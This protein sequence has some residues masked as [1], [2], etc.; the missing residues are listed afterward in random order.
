MD[1]DGILLIDKPYGC[2]SFD[3]IRQLKF[4]FG[5][6]K[7]GHAGT[8]DPLATGLLIVVLGKA[9]KIS[10]QLMNGVKTYE[11]SFLLGM[12]TTTYDCEGDTVETRSVNGITAEDVQVAMQGFLGDQYQQPPMFSARKIHGVPLYKLAR[13]GQTVE[14]KPSF[15]TLFKFDCIHYQAPE[16]Q[17]CVKCSKGTYVRS[18]AHD[19]GQKLGCGA[20]LSALRRTQSGKFTL[21]QAV[22]MPAL[23]EHA[24]LENLKQH[25]LPCDSFLGFV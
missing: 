23:L 6:K 14:R 22:S 12:E 10:Q 11:G 13:K 7:L 21:Q 4:Y 19:L 16:V 20:H 15:I 25:I 5:I 9:T 3:V 8:L 24:S 17:F 2:S 1:L 18:L